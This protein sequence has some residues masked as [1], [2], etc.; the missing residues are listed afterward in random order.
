M[1]DL[2][3]SVGFLLADEASPEQRAA[4]N[5]ATDAGIDTDR[6]GPDELAEGTVPLSR[7]DVLWWH[8]DNPID[9]V[10]GLDDWLGH[11]SEWIEAGGGVLL[12]LRALEAIEPLGIDPI[13]PDTTGNVEPEHELG[14]LCKSIHAD[15]PVFEEFDALRIP[16]RAAHGIQQF[17][18]Y[19]AVL[20]EHGEVLA[21]TIRA[22]ED[23]P[24]QPA[25][26]GWQY[27]DG[28]VAGLGTA[29]TFAGATNDRCVHNRT[30]LFRNLLSVLAG[31][32]RL[33]E[34][35]PKDV[36]QLKTMRKNLSDDRHR[37]QYHI[38]AP[39]NWLNDPNG[40]IHWNGEFHVFYQYN[41][42]GPYHDTIHW[43]HA[44]SADLVHW[45]D[46]PVALTPSP[47]GPDRDGCWSGCAFDDDGTPRIMYTGGRG[48]LQLP[49]LATA[50]DADLNTWQKDPE[51]PIIDTLPVDPPLR[52]TEHWK[53]EFR[54]H[55]VWREGDT[56]Y[57]L[58]GSG[59]EGGGGTALLYSSEDDELR[60]WYYEG[61]ILTGDPE[62]DGAMW[63]C[64]EL[65]DLGEKQLLHISN[66]DE[67]RYYLG[68]Y[69]NGEFETEQTAQLDYGDFYAP[70]SLRADDGRILTWG[71]IWEARDERAQWDAGWSGAL[72]LPRELDLNDRGLLRQRPARELESLRERHVH[73]GSRSLHDQWLDLDTD[74]LSY[75]LSAE[76]K[77]DDAEAF[78]IVVG[79]SP[80]G[81][82]RTPIR[83]T[84]DS[85]L[86]VDRSHSS[87]DERAS[88]APDRM[89][90][91]P[92]DEPLSLRLFVD[93]SVVELFA[94]E[95]HCLTTRI[96]PT[97]GD[98][99]NL[100]LHAKGGT[101]ELLDLDVWELGRA[102]TESEELSGEQA[103]GQTD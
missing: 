93:G 55:N 91:A 61:P 57:Q 89:P 46:R 52:S 74:G 18:R 26:I 81:E 100:S 80:D 56:W 92:V 83:Y 73:E 36:N 82:E 90:I 23:V 84:R 101:V 27:G 44:V 70:Q 1:T 8:R 88:K 50:A 68:S 67:V 62:P 38:T 40:L 64:P 2:P 79:E 75:E 98:S 31:E 19:D 42:G 102:W 29:V 17:A 86:V 53:A 3:D 77:L 71:W 78:E 32:Q 60:Q 37:P 35:R 13:A 28:D 34:G 63:E 72:S 6:V 30:R 47:D 12:T 39:A 95:R 5:W 41:P 16:T 43:G 103:P 45:E 11:L 15:G 99:D 96:Y 94:N 69:E 87:L 76:I 22:G 66:Y 65:L 97:R 14:L 48:K 33:T 54:D 4:L 49:C 51:N 9:A 20:P 10:G 59:V 58:I 85:E 21:S 25:L 7:Y 24:D